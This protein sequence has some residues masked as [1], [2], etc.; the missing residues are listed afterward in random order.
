M[1]TYPVG[2]GSGFTLTATNQIAFQAGSKT[3]ARPFDDSV[4]LYAQSRTMSFANL[5]ASIAAGG[6]GEQIFD[7]TN[8]SYVGVSGSG[9]Q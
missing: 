3:Q 8:G 2:H 5:L 7:A 6:F 4:G 9:T 1:V